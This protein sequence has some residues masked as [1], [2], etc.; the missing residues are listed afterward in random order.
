MMSFNSC[1][2]L[3]FLY[4]NFVI[5]LFILQVLS[6]HLSFWVRGA[7]YFI[8][9]AFVDFSEPCQLSLHFPHVFN[10]FLIPLLTVSHQNEA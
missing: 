1:Y 4:T 9:L 7:I 6:F 5:Q 3:T 10:T 2:L 8:E